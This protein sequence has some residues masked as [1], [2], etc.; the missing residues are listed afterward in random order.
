MSSVLLYSIL[1]VE[2]VY[3][4]QLLSS[5]VQCGRF[6]DTVCVYRQSY[7]AIRSFKEIHM[8]KITLPQPHSAIQ[9]SPNFQS[10]DCR[11]AFL[12]NCAFGMG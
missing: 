5:V 9:H 2:I 12:A 8:T 3:S 7:P 6:I 10:R 1:S 4:V 11:A